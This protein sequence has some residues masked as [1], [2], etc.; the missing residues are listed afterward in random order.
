MNRETRDHE[1]HEYEAGG[2]T[3]PEY[4]PGDGRLEWVLWASIV[5]SAVGLAYCVVKLTQVLEGILSW[6]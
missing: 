3:E 2:H 6:Q 4:L 5:I 1:P